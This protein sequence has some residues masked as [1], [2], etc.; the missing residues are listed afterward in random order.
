[1]H[2]PKKTTS[3][4][5][6]PTYTHCAFAMCVSPKRQR[7]CHH[8]Q[9]TFA[10]LVLFAPFQEDV[11]NATIINIVQVTKAINYFLP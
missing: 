5:P 11:V 9:P 7:Q 10:L 2:F 8:H 1:M 6:S 3:M 4:P